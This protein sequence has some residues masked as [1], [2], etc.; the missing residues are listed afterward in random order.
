MNW[1]LRQMEIQ[2]QILTH[3]YYCISSSV[4]II[5]ILGDSAVDLLL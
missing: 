2:L 3:S 1:F 4:S 5:R